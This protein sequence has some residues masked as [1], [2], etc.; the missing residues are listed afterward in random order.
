LD[1]A[2]FYGFIHCRHDI[3]E[4]RC[5]IDIYFF[6]FRYLGKY[7]FSELVRLDIFAEAIR[8]ISSNE[9]RIILH[10]PLA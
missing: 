5:G 8:K 6:S 10:H 1:R 3:I 7:I 9:A 4:N 2:A